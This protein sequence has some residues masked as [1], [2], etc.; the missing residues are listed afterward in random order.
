MTLQDDLR[1]RATEQREAVGPLMEDGGRKLIKVQTDEDGRLMALDATF[2]LV[3]MIGLQTETLY[4]L[5]AELLDHK[6][7]A[8]PESRRSERL[9]Q[10]LEQNNAIRLAAA[11]ATASGDWSDFNRLVNERIASAGASTGTNTGGTGGTEPTPGD[12]GSDGDGGG[13]QPTG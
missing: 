11:A 4:M 2:L 13:S 10:I 9:S 12:S 1:R 6:R 8:E 7:H 3:A 5:H